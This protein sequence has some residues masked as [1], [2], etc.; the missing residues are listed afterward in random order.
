MTDPTPAPWSVISVGTR[1]A[2]QYVVMGSGEHL[3]RFGGKP[4]DLANARLIA[5]AP[6]LLDAA[7]RAAE[8]LRANL[9]EDTEHYI[10]GRAR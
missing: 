5:A 6:D 2:I 3:V 9:D 7:R 10:C 4:K 1:N 8:Y